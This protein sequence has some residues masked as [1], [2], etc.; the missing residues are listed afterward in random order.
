MSD[1]LTQGLGHLPQRCV[2]PCT[3]SSKSQRAVLPLQ[4]FPHGGLKVF[5]KSL[6]LPLPGPFLLVTTPS[7]SQT[8]EVRERGAF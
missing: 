4:T 8:R 5:P 1:L 2:C 3:R 6:H 7:D